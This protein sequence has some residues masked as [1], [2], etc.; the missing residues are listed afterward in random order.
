[1]LRNGDPERPLFVPWDD[2]V[3][4]RFGRRVAIGRTYQQ[5]LAGPTTRNDFTSTAC[6]A[7]R[8]PFT[9][10]V[11]MR[12]SQA[13]ETHMSRWTAMLHLAQIATMALAMV[14]ASVLIYTGYLFV[15]EPLGLLKQAIER[16]QGAT[17]RRGS[18]RSVQRRI[19]HAGRRFQRH[20][21][22]CAVDVP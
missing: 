6:T 18:N 12:W 7:T 17:F 11:S 5:P 22:P 15:L 10:T 14:G 19:R 13:I 16:M 1:M 21:R 9:V 20:G 3:R 8:R 2:T 4:A